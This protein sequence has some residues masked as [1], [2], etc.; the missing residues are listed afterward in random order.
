MTNI[1]VVTASAT[2]KR[3]VV[4]A[5]LY[6]DWAVLDPELTTALPPAVTAATGMDAMVRQ[7]KLELVMLR[8]NLGWLE[9][10]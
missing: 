9:Y 6:A 7:R 1:S 3:G 5:Q 4:A 8:F 2:E 10:S